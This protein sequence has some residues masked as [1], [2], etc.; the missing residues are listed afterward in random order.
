MKKRNFKALCVVLALV[1]LSL[2]ATPVFSAKDFISQTIT[3]NHQLGSNFKPRNYPE[4]E[5][6]ISGG[7]GS[8][9]GPEFAAM[10]LLLV[11]SNTG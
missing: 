5:K 9:V 10:L 11:G 8:P 1:M 4:T 6:A 7:K 3:K 2:A